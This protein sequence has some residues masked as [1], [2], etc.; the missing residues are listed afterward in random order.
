VI[1][2][3]DA[4]VN[5]IDN[6]SL[7]FWLNPNQLST[8]NTP[9]LIGKDDGIPK[10][11]L[12]GISF[13]NQNNNFNLFISDLSQRQ[14][15]FRFTNVNSWHSIVLTKENN[16]YKLYI[17]G[18]LNSTINNAPTPRTANSMTIGSASGIRFFKGYL[19]DFRIYN[20]ALSNSEVQVL[21]HE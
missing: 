4:P 15:N 16:V 10:P 20:R 5:T 21:Y 19:D 7:S 9:I 12:N 14:T 18:L 1:S 3:I 6:F 13:F 17:N 8:I 11:S 2:F